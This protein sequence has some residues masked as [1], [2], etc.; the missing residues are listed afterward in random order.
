MVAVVAHA[1]G[2]EPAQ[3]AG[4][5]P[6]QVD[7]TGVDASAVDGP[8]VD[9]S[10]VAGAK[11]VLWWVQLIRASVVS[12]AD[13][14]E[15]AG[16][17]VSL[18]TVLVRELAAI[19]NAVGALKAKAAAVVAG[20]DSWKAAGDKSPAHQI[21]R[22]TGVS[23][24]EAHRVVGT[25]QRLG[26][27]PVLDRVAS[28]G[29]L[30]ATQTALIARA[31][32]A[33]PSAARRLI[34][35][36]RVVGVDELRRECA[37]VIAAADVDAE[38]RHAR[39]H[40]ARFA[41]RRHLDDGSARLTYQSTPEEVDEVWRVVSGYGAAAFDRARLDGR[42]ETQGAYQADGLLAM[43]RAA[44]V[45]A[46]GASGTGDSAGD[47]GAGAGG[48]DLG[49]HPGDSAGEAGETGGSAGRAGR[50]GRAGR[51]GRVR[52]PVPVKVIVNI[53]HGAL[54]RGRVEGGEVCE[55]AGVGP[56]PV[57][58][59][60]EILASGDPFLAAVV[61]S[62]E[63][64]LSVAHLGRRPTAKMTTAL[65]WAGVECRRLGCGATERLQLDHREDWAD[66][67][68]TRVAALEW[69]CVP[70]HNLKTRHGWALVAG[71]GSRE[72][73]APDDP[74][75]PGFA[76]RPDRHRPP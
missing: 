26:A 23:V 55:I 72:M 67:R 17:G 65:Q 19:E 63:E 27:Q 51:K 49:D 41:S 28:S 68:V 22:E 15:T 61:T 74:R 13:R 44:A 42:R 34:E 47:A 40:K 30:S 32:E 8:A 53:D 57:S 38:A 60:A 56:V 4:V 46:A 33:D 16:M 9:A 64:V 70:D 11:R 50:V 7:G 69:L 20:S 3:V 76:S 29:S 21:A 52:R 62:G 59:V 48:V 45:S 37:R 58:V 66:T 5:E 31:V 2:V 35:F 36:A 6:A 73:V 12:V 39:V 75:H 24:G 71:T 14:F 43:A 18:A 54:Q 25:G 1:A 10:G